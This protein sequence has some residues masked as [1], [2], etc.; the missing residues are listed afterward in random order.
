MHTQQ[1]SVF[2]PS[3]PNP[4]IHH[5]TPYSQPPPPPP[6]QEA[7]D[8]SGSGMMGMVNIINAISSDSN[9]SVHA[10]KRQRQESYQSVSHICSGNY[11]HLPWSHIPITFTAADIRLQHYPH[12]DPLFIRANIGKNTKYYFGNDVGRVLMDNG[13]SDGYI[14]LAV[15]FWHGF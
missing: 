12:N 7:P 15:F 9:E 3:W 5:Q 14:D 13:S 4:P 8:S 2:V 1:P 6:K 11:F 10:T